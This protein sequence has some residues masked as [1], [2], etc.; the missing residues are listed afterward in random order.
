MKK[1]EKFE[2]RQVIKVKVN[3]GYELECTFDDGTIKICDMSFVRKKNAPMLTPFKKEA[4]FKKVFIEM[5]APT[6]P[7]GYDICADFIYRTGS[8]VQK[9]RKVS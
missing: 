6:W 3:P 8:M 4:F 9:K 5:G 7:N 2:L 1:V